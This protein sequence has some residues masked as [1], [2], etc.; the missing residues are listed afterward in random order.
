MTK[1]NYAAIKTKTEDI[2]AIERVAGTIE[3][4]AEETSLFGTVTNCESLNIRK[5]PRIDADV[6]YRVEVK[7]ELMID[8]SKSTKEWYHVYNSGGIEG[9]C[10]KK[11]VTVK[12]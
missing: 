9:Y 11:Y 8:K 3:E 1:R 4:V 10:M 12:E 2:D 5:K 7:T 6:M